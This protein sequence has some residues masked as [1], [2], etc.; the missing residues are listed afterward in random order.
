MRLGA[1]SDRIATAG[2]EVIAV[3]VDDDDRQAGMFARWPTPHVRYVSDPDGHDILRPLGLYDPEERG[4]IGLPAF[5]VY[6]PDGAE[7]YRKVGRD[8]ADRTADTEMFDAVEA[9]GLDAIDPPAG[10]PV[11][12]VPDDVHG[13]FPTEWLF[14]YFRGN[15]FAAVA[16]GSRT[17]DTDFRGIARQHRLM[18]DATLEAWER[19]KDRTG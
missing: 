19:V 13:F 17:D 9:L 7:V 12:D 1:E 10:G 18:C 11:A 15:R 4:G 14:P 2:A 3:S 5:I 6:D 16:I 8:F